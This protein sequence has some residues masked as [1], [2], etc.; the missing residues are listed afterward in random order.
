MV[1]WI[2]LGALT[3]LVVGLLVRPLVA[4]APADRARADYDLA[5]YRDQL[6]EIERD[7]ARGSLDEAE[8]AAARLGI[9]RRILA[10]APPPST[11]PATEATTAQVKPS[12]GG[13]GARY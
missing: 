12:P 3:A 1:L 5:I 13:E 9:E 4:G 2:V 7:R 10:P 11:P 6:A 8:A